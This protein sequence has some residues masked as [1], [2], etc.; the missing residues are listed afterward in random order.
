APLTQYS[1]RERLQ[2]HVAPLSSV[3]RSASRFM[4]A[5]IRT[6]PSFA[7]C[8]TAGTSPFASYFIVSRGE[9]L[10]PPSPFP[11][12]ISSSLVMTF[13]FLRQL[14]RVLERDR[15]IVDSPPHHHAL[16]HWLA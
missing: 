11:L 7:S 10:L 3:R 14:Q 13:F 9:P 1:W 8:T 6:C 5:T 4:Y 2:K 15:P 12:S 16:E